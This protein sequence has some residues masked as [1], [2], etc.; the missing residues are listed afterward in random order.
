MTE[1]KKELTWDELREQAVGT[2]LHDEFIKGIR[3]I[4][5]CG[6]VSLC[7]YVGIPLDHPL[8]GHGY[9][10]LPIEAHGGL[11]F[12]STPRDSWPE[13]YYWYGWDYAHSG[14]YCFYY[15]KPPLV[16]EFD[17][18]REHKWLVKEVV[19]DSWGTLYDFEKLMRFAESI[20]KG[21]KHD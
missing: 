2:I 11:T 16:G 6:P 12:S 21:D 17:H 5:M 1:T 3:F 8:A 7:G 18:Q 13:G 9:D 4:V 20:V 10:D 15:D 19:K 14:D